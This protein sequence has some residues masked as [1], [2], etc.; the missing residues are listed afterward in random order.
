[1]DTE[2][3]TWCHEKTMTPRQTRRKVLRQASPSQGTPGRQFI[4]LQ[5]AEVVLPAKNV[6][7]SMRRPVIARL[8]V[9]ARAHRSKDD[10]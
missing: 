5:S 7:H 10:G 6:R 9:T 4:T 1:M 8:V 2:R 3:Q